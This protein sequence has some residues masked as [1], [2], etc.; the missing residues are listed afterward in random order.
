[1]IVIGTPHGANR[2]ATRAFPENVRAPTMSHYLK[3][4]PVPNPLPDGSLKLSVEERKGLLS[5]FDAEDRDGGELP[6]YQDEEYAVPRDCVALRKRGISRIAGGFIVLI[7][8]FSFLAPTSRMWCG[9]MGATN[10]LMDPSRLL[11]NG[12]HEFKP[13]VLI[14]SLDGLR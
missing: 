9:G 7:L 14:V 3:G 2:T 11:N 6:R 5:N 10:R 1:M 12:T 4:I 8:C 13:T